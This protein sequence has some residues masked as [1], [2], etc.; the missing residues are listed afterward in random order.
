[1]AENKKILFL[2]HRIPYPPNK[3]DKIRTFNEIKYLS[4]SFS[5]ELMA[6]AD[7]K[8]DLGFKKNLES[9]CHR[10]HLFPLNPVWGKLRGVRSL[11]AGNSISEGYFFQADFYK[12]LSE[13]LSRKTYHAVFCF[14]SPMAAHVFK[15]YSQQ[16]KR[17]ERPGLV[18]DFCDVDSEKW[19]QYADRSSFLLRLLYKVEAKRVL[20]FEKKTNQ[21][22]DASVFVSE[23]E[24]RLFIQRTGDAK[25]VHTLPNGVDHTYFSCDTMPLASEPDPSS[26]IIMFAG[27]MDYYANVEGV[28]WFCK[29]VFPFIRA[30]IPE[31]MFFIVGNNPHFRVRRLGNLKNVVVTGFVEDIRPYYKRARV[32][33]VP[34]RIARG[35]QNKV[36]EAMAMEKPVVLTSAALCGIPACPGEHLFLADTPTAFAHDVL[37]LLNDKELAVKTGNSARKFTKNNFSWKLSMEKLKTLLNNAS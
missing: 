8:S 34:L 31:A 22:F 26:K 6:L 13:L 9:Y 14:S 25:K 12:K 18:M 27:A 5:I 15:F 10:V 23:E 29:A 24:S 21:F 35:I 19:R 37:M 28:E 4:E 2:A 1:M 32:C 33:V 36:L 30:R 7:K 16:G 11:L 3:G 17:L 20:A